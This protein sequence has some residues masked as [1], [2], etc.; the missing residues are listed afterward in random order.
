M[1]ITKR[2][3]IIKKI[4]KRTVAVET[5][6]MKTHPL[7]KKRFKVM[8]KYLA[9]D[10]EDKF[11]EGDIVVIQECKPLSKQKRFK[12]IEKI[13]STYV[14]EDKIAGEEVLGAE[15]PKEEKSES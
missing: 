8:K 13:G 4:D 10:K 3:T 1:K 7:Y 15:E 9:D 5:F 14:T 11:S 2:G 12:V 6:S